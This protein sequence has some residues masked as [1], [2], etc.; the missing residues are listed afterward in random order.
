MDEFGNTLI[1]FAIHSRQGRLVESL[2]K[3]GYAANIADGLG[4]T[5]FWYAAQHSDLIAMK[6]LKDVADVDVDHM[7]NEGRT[8][9]AVATHKGSYISIKFLLDLN[10]DANP[11]RL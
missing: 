3:K 1:S 10:L 6:S 7:D 11:R 4:R 2:L 9:L 5:P 8:P